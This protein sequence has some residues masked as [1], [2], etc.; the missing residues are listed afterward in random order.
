MHSILPITILD[1]GQHRRLGGA[2]SLI[3]M[4][5]VQILPRLSALYYDVLL[6]FW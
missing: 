5:H 2:F 3:P 1:L 6:L 4:S